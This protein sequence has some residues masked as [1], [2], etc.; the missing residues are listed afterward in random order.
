MHVT[1]YGPDGTLTLHHAGHTMQVQISALTHP[2][3]IPGTEDPNA[4][5]TPEM[6]SDQGVIFQTVFP[7]LGDGHAQRLHAHHAYHA[8]G[9]ASFDA[10]AKHTIARILA[11]GGTPLLDR[12]VLMA[13]SPPVATPPAPAAASGEGE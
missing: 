5:V 9:H 6:V 4:L 8:G 1:D 10:A 3:A 12:H 13:A 2:M 11:A 7:M